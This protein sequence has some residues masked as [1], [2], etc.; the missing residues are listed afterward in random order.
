M[1]VIFCELVA[2]F[3]F[4]EAENESIQPRIMTGLLPIASNGKRA[5][6]LSIT[7]IL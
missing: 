1:Q 5:L 7:R 4:A 3:S 2:K 6:P